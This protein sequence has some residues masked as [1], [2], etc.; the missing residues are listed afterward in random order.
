[1]SNLPLCFHMVNLS[2]DRVFCLCWC[3]L[4]TV[5]PPEDAAPWGDGGDAVGSAA[6]RLSSASQWFGPSQTS[7][8]CQSFS[9]QTQTQPLPGRGKRW[10][11]VSNHWNQPPK[12]VRDENSSLVDHRK[13]DTHLFSGL[14][15]AVVDPPAQ[16]RTPAGNVPSNLKLTCHR[17]AHDST[18]DICRHL[19]DSAL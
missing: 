5:T 6:E 13:D 14:L 19:G 11:G 18:G 10:L 16:A 1:M 2:L 12:P 9:C 15:G 3:A 17:V 8:T 7:G 4:F